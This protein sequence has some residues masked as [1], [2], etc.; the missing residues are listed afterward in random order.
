[1]IRRLL[2]LA[3]LLAPALPALAQPQQGNRPAAAERRAFASAEEGTRALLA[4]MRAPEALGLAAIVGREVIAS[5]PQGER[6]A[7]EIRR[8]AGAW[9]EGQGF[10]IETLGAD[11]ARALFGTDRVAL[12]VIWTRGPRGWTVDPAATVTAL[13]ERRIGV[14]EAN[15]IRALRAIVEAQ[16]LYREANPEGAEVPAFAR[17]IRSSPGLRDGLAGSY[18]AVPGPVVD[19]LNQAFAEAE[20]VPGQPGLLPPAGYGYRILEAQGAAA[21]GGARSFMEAGRLT[22]GFAVLA[23]PV[24][25]G[26]TGISTF[27]VDDRG[28]LFERDFGAQTIAEAARILAFDPGPG[29]VA[30][31]E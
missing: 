7:T 6:A 1:M 25:P 9:L 18:P 19:F 4:A 22:G 3:L 23:W 10:V 20:G 21:P 26:E 31:A 13:R 24:R 27:L 15:A 12:P 2:V 30:V 11:R 5:V 28:A 14:N 17:R 8:A 16:A 29:W